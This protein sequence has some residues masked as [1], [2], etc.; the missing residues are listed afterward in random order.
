[1]NEQDPARHNMQPPLPTHPPDP[2]AAGDADKIVPD[3]KPGTPN[4]SK[5]HSV[6]LAPGQPVDNVGGPGLGDAPAA[7]GHPATERDQATRADDP[8][9]QRDKSS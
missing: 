1:M 9:D 6:G 8:Q 2:N 3:A 4:D 5:L 7:S